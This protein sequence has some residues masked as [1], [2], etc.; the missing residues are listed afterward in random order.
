MGEVFVQVTEPRRRPVRRPGPS[1]IKMCGFCRPFR[2]MHAQTCTACSWCS[3]ICSLTSL[4][5]RE[6]HASSDVKEPI[7]LHEAILPVVIYINSSTQ[8]NSSDGD[9][10]TDRQLTTAHDSQHECQEADADHGQDYRQGDETAESAVRQ[11]EHLGEDGEQTV[12]E[13]A[14]LLPA[15]QPVSVDPVRESSLVNIFF[16]SGIFY[17]FWFH[18]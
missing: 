1:Q 16:Y 14:S 17:R 10:S 13:E 18:A 2:A 6:L 9:D 5:A 7:S 3:E 4:D 11:P 12:D 8:D 15:E